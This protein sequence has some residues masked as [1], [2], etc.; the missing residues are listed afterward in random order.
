MGVAYEPDISVAAFACMVAPDGEVTDYLRLPALLKRRNGFR[1]D[2]KM[3]KV[4]YLP[5]I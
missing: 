3:Q 4:N 1:E 5:I 2:D